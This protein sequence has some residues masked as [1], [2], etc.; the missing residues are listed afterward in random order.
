MISV[1]ALVERA[2]TAAE[3]TTFPASCAPDV[4]RFLAVL[5]GGVPHGGAILEIGTGAGIGTAWLVS[6]LDG[7]NDATL[8]TIEV[9]RERSE[10]TAAFGW[11]E[12]TRFHQG[13][14][15]DVLPRLGQFDLVF[16]DAEG[17]K[18]YGLEQTLDAVRPGGL[19]VVD[20]MTPPHEGSEQ[21]RAM[22]AEVREALMNDE[23]LVSAELHFASGVIVSRK[24]T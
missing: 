21:H 11:P 15:L 18:W 20:D 1:P 2:T 22:T 12:W 19:L 6:G 14:A 8:D 3:A 23:R 24:R 17:G 10:L 7:R 5:A 9:D 16:A 4:G 13:D